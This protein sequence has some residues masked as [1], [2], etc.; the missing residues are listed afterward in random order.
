MNTVSEAQMLR[1]FGERLQKKMDYANTSQAELAEELGVSQASI[2]R[3]LNGVQ[4][5]PLTVFVNMVYYFDC[6][7]SELLDFYTRV[8]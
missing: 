4:M 3:Y 6:D 1:Y 8:V 2:S 7:P 5:P